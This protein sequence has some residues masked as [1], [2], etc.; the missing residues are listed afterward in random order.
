MPCVA[1]TPDSPRPQ[2]KQTNRVAITKD[3]DP[4]SAMESNPRTRLSTT[5]PPLSSG[6]SD[7]PKTKSCRS[8][9]SHL[10][11]IRAGRSHR[12]RSP[13]PQIRLP[14]A[15]EAL[16]TATWA[17]ASATRFTIGLRCRHRGCS[18]PVSHHNTAQ[19]CIFAAALARTITHSAVQSI[20]ALLLLW[21][22]LSQGNNQSN[23]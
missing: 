14:A 10:R 11:Q 22:M 18:L 15:A 3:Q 4:R 16:P 20:I 8:S 17:R 9:G 19:G 2:R 21:A 6:K 7:A 12:G 23:G 5:T 1:P 13:P